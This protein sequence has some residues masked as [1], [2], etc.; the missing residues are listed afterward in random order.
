MKAFKCD[1]CGKFYGKYR[2]TNDYQFRGAP[3][4]VCNC[5]GRGDCNE[6]LDLCEECRKELMIFMKTKAEPVKDCR[7]CKYAE[8]PFCV[9]KHEGGICVNMESYIERND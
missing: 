8:G 3:I 5:N 2:L 4:S 1:R 7:T 9:L 6:V